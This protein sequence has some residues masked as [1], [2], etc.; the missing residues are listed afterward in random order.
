MIERY[1]VKNRETDKKNEKWRPRYHFTAPISWMN[2]PNGLIYYRGWYHLFYQYNPKNCDWAC[3]HWGHAV[4]RDIIHWK[5]MPIALKPDQPYDNHSEGGCFSGSAVEKDGTMYLF[6]S[7]TIKKNGRT[8]QTQCIAYSDDGVH[9]Q[10]YAGNPVVEKP[11]P[12]VSDD[13]RDPKVFEHAGKWYMVVGGSIG[14]ADSGG[15]GR[16]FLYE[17]KN[18]FDWSYKGV[19]LVSGG[20]MGTMFECPDLYEI[21]GKWVL[22]CS[23]MNHPTLNKAL[24]CV[25][26]M[27]F[28]K[29]E[30]EIE[31]IGTLDTGFDYYAPQTFLDKHRNRV[32]VAWQNGWLW[33]PWCEGWGPTSVENWRGTLS[34]P[35]VVTLNKE[36]EICL[37]PVE[38]LETLVLSKKVLK[39]VRVT[40]EKYMIFPEVPKSF[41]L[42]IRLDVK[43]IRSRYLEI[44]VLGK[45]D[46]ATVISVDLLENILSVDKNN[47]DLYGRGRMNRIFHREDNRMEIM[48]LVDCSSVEVYAERG[49]YCITS[50]VYPA[51]D[52]TECWIRTPYKEAV[53]DEI[54]VSSLDGIWD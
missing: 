10:K 39:E 30:Y 31:K 34:I 13:F 35:R 16:V 9:F 22:T 5:D 12:E 17:S 49:R 27:N 54:T 38:E 24:Y 3:M 19:I 48:I 20:R 51:P 14:G 25:G 33:M 28:E 36:D 46:H 47:G 42:L 52:Q 44:G 11:Y 37:Y 18:I 32:M 2:D 1:I 4:S 53:I 6:Y 15:D 41:R 43:K 45:D 21:N 7:A 26:Q 23:P 29:G 50:N 40:R 8:K